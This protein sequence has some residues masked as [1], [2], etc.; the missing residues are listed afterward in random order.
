MSFETSQNDDISVLPKWKILD[1]N[2]DYEWKGIYT[3]T[4]VGFRSCQ[5]IKKLRR[6]GAFLV[7]YKMYNDK[8]RL[9]S[10]CS[11]CT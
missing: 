3:S 7:L 5:K 11:S 9:S 2:C 10:L 6:E 1:E 8:Q 4:H